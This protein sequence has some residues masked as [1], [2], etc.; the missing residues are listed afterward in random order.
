MCENLEEGRSYGNG[1][2]AGSGQNS[3]RRGDTQAKAGRKR[4]LR[5]R[6][7]LSPAF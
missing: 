2:S 1:S 6:G 3:A 4:S 7:I 5:S